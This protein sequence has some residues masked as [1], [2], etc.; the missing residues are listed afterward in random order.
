VKHFKVII[1]LILRE[2]YLLNNSPILSIKA[3]EKSYANITALKNLDLEI[4]SGMCTALL[5]PNG[6]GKTTTCDLI[7]GIIKADSGKIEILGKTHSKYKKNI[8]KYMGVQLQDTRLYGRY[9]V[10]ETL[11]LFA[12]FYEKHQEISESLKIFQLT[13]IGDK[14][15][16]KLSQGQRQ[17]VHLACTMIHEPALLILDEPTN[18]LDPRTKH[19]LWGYLRR[20]KQQGTAILLTTHNMEEA[21]Y[22]ADHVAILVKGRVLKSGSPQEL[23]KKI[24]GSEVL[25]FVLEKEKNFNLKN[26]YKKNSWIQKIRQYENTFFLGSNDATKDLEEIKLLA[27]EQNF[28]LQHLSIKKATLEDVFLTVTIE[29]PQV[30]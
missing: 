14:R 12:S 22:L 6:A 2:I 25:S 10:R 13:E 16:G 23:I 7:S 28:V 30:C 27:K 1:Y 11:S 4:K 24:C 19:E 20:I 29:S 5:G 15:L 21:E 26:A 8:Y 3:L 17:R 9:T 18:S